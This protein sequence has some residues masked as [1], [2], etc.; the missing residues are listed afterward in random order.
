MRG[1]A[2]PLFRPSRYSLHG[3]C[4]LGCAGDVFAP[5][6][7]CAQY[8]WVEHIRS[9]SLSCLCAAQVQLSVERDQPRLGGVPTVRLQVRTERTYTDGPPSP[10]PSFTRLKPITGTMYV[11]TSID[12]LAACRASLLAAILNVIVISDSASSAR[13]DRRRIIGTI[14][15]G[16]VC[17]EK[18]LGHGSSQT[19][20]I[21]RW[22]RS[23]NWHGRYQP[24]RLPWLDEQRPAVAHKRRPAN[25]PLHQPLSSINDYHVWIG[26]ADGRRLRS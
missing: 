6:D 8:G 2:C 10:G 11:I 16:G 7:A 18:R 20:T 1:C 17:A 23:I 22:V 25:H 24:T 13:I 12:G 3:T 4:T 15:G 26:T 19:N 9:V 5:S 21:Y 14:D